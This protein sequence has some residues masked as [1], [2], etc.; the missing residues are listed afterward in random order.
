LRCFRNLYPAFSPDPSALV[1]TIDF[2]VFAALYVAS[3]LLLIA[4]LWFCYDRRE[5]RLYH[6]ERAKAIFHCVRCGHLYDRRGTRELA[7]CPK[8]EAENTRLRF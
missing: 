8:C 1:F 7:P 2:S 3:G 5:K 4:V 6:E